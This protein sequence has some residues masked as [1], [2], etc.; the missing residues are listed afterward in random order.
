MPPSASPPAEKQ[1]ALQMTPLQEA[2]AAGSSGND[3]QSATAFFAMPTPKRAEP[4]PAPAPPPSPQ[5]MR[6][7]SQ[8]MGPPP[9]PMPSMT[10][11]PPG[12][13]IKGP[14]AGAPMQPMPSAQ[15]GVYA[16]GPP[17]LTGMA[18]E[19]ERAQSYRV[20]GLILSFVGLICMGLVVTMGLVVAAVV[21]DEDEEPT[22]VAVVAPPQ[23]P[24][25]MIVDTGTPAPKAAPKP[26]PRPVNSATSPT[27]RPAAPRPAPVVAPSGPASAT[28]KMTGSVPFTGIEINC[29]MSSF[30]QRASFAGGTA[31]VAGVP[32]E[33]CKVTFKGG[34]PATFNGIRGGETRTC[35][36]TNGMVVCT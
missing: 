30:R 29:P 32:V 16:Q 35:E 22:P 24:P 8:P 17:T 7:G 12:M 9:Q 36:Y 4:P 15:H 10:G 23:A 34:P 31:T 5:V 13:G 19:Q 21:F 26:R 27:P 28:I 14:V 33:E 20:F 25:K 18:P 3:N 11:M 1:Q 2:D 6:A